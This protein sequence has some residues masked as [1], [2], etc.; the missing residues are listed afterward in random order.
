VARAEDLTTKFQQ[1]M[2]AAVKVDGFSGSVL[3]SRGGETLFA[4]GYGLA[5][6][7][8]GVPNTPRTKF[9]IGSIT[10]QFTAMVLAEQGKLELVDPI[11]KYVEDAPKTWEKVMIHHLLTHTSGVFDFSSAPDFEKLMAQPDTVPSLIARFR[12]RPLDIPPGE[13]CVYSN[14]GYI[15]L[16]A[17]IEKASRMSYEAFLNEAIFGPLGLRDTGYD[18]SETILP[19][20][21]AGY[22]R[23]GDELQNAPYHHMSQPYAAGALYSTVEDLAR[24]DRALNDGKLISKESYTRMYTPGK[25]VYAYGWAVRTVSGRKEISH[26]GGTYGF[27]SRISRYP[28]PQ[29][30]VVV[31]SNV[32]PSRMMEVSRALA[33]ITFGDEYKVLEERKAVKVDPV[34]LDSYV[35]RYELRPGSM[36]TVRRSGDHLEA[37]VPE[38]NRMVFL[39]ASE[40]EFLAK[41]F[42]ARLTFVKD[43]QGKVSHLVPH[44]GPRVR[45]SGSRSRE[46]S[47]GSRDP[48]RVSPLINGRFNL[49]RGTELR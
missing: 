40:S 47:P 44:L 46:T 28:D 14:S 19:N 49:S 45:R 30:C 43:P 12:D 8:L 37:Q 13:K 27:L 25:D 7:E 15:L 24:R 4:R 38:W 31:L 39:P 16:G 21:A 29:V 35:G 18:H 2:D 33:A 32:L 41:Y 20:R 48:S 11:G 34:V 42:D 36:L 26:V 10:K 1:Y 3:V 9:R 6:I 22:E 23:A 17:V 5:N